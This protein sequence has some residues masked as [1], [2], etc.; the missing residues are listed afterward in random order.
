MKKILFTAVFIFATINVSHAANLTS[1]EIKSDYVGHSY[2]FKTKEDATGTI[3]VSKNGKLKLSKTNFA[4]KSD[5][6]TWVV[7]GNKFCNSWK[8]IRKGKEKCFSINDSG[9]NKYRYS[10]G[11]VLVRK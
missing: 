9:N 7:K 10:D 6:G 2:T 11:T 5:S 4:L 8:K 3:K 1:A